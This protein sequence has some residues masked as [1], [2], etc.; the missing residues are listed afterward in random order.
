VPIDKRADPI[1]SACQIAAQRPRSLPRARGGAPSGSGSLPGRLYRRSR[2]P[3]RNEDP[4]FRSAAGRTGTLIGTAGA[5]SDPWRMVPS[6]TTA[7]ATN[8]GSTG[9]NGS[10]F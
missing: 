9:S 3:G 8:S 6:P 4:L 2:H 10:G 1:A 5:A 7:P